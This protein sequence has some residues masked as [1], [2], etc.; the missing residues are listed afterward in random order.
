MRDNNLQ[1]SPSSEFTEAFPSAPE[2]NELGLRVQAYAGPLRFRIS[3]PFVRGLFES[4]PYPE[5]PREICSEVVARMMQ[6]SPSRR[7]FGTS[8][9]A[10]FY[11]AIPGFI[12]RTARE[13]WKK[14]LRHRN[15]CAGPVEPAI[16]DPT[17]Q[18]EHLE[19][20]ASVVRSLNPMDRQRASLYLELL[21]SLPPDQA[22]ARVATLL[23][24]T[25]EV[26]R[27][28]LNRLRKALE[29][30]LGMTRTP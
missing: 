18:G 28:S 8:K 19:F 11:N 21:D 3:D 9:K 25:P 10:V 17:P 30:A 16:E 2:R 14:G 24:V 5:F 7:V 13:V 20:A 22:E 12:Q 23:K 4:P 15:R 29:E 6:W 1:I 27:A 26:V